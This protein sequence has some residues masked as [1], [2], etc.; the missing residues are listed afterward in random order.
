MVKFVG[1]GAPG[2]IY[3]ESAEDTEELPVDGLRTLGSLND[4]K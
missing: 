2:F 4:S 1:E 3:F